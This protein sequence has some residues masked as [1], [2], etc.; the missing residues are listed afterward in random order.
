MKNMFLFV[1]CNNS[2][3]QGDLCPHCGFIITLPPDMQPECLCYGKK[4]EE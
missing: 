4:V 2:L 1:G 3:N